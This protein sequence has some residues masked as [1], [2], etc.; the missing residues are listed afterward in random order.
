MFSQTFGPAL[1]SSVLLAGRLGIIGEEVRHLCR[2]ILE[3]CKDFLSGGKIE[4]LLAFHHGGADLGLIAI[5][6]HHFFPLLDG[7]LLRGGNT[8]AE[9]DRCDGK[10]CSDHAQALPL[11]RWRME[12]SRRKTPASPRYSSKP[13]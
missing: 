13:C 2:R 5:G 12:T 10:N 6:L 4:R 8:D 7:V 3:R 1:K 11:Q 9:Y